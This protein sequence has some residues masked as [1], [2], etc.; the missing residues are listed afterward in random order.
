MR[1][2]SGIAALCIAVSFGT[3]GN[4]TLNLSSIGP[5]YD[6]NFDTLEEIN[7]Q[8][9][10]WMNDTTLPGWSLFRVTSN[11][12]STPFPIVAYDVSDGNHDS[13]RFYSFGVSG[14]TDRALGALGA[15]LFGDAPS[16]GNQTAVSLNAVAGW[17]TVAFTN[18]TS[19]TFSGFTL[20]YDGEQWRDAGDNEPPVQQTMEFEYGFGGTFSTV[21]TWSK[22]G[23]DFDFVS[24]VATTVSGPVDGNGV[25]LVADRGG[26]IGALSW[27]PGQTLWLRW[28]ERN[29]NGFDHGLAI[30]NFSFSAVP[31]PGAMVLGGM[32]SGLIG[33]AAF[34]RRHVAAFFQ[35]A[36][37]PQKPLADGP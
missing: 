14:N 17:I 2:S 34:L 8:A 32:L 37:K 4:A 11:T 30:D 12:N 13:G 6:Q 29:D 22:P 27:A 23:G 24:P 16:P 19:I 3:P 5:V 28:I 18:D 20:E 10:G 25:G 21:A 7:Q 36:T 35:K 15:S 31:E 26:T 1:S 9:A 33:L